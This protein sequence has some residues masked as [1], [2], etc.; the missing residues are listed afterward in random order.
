MRSTLFSRKGVW[1]VLLAVVFWT[2]AWQLASMAVDLPLLLPGPLLVVKAFWNLAGD[3]EFWAMVS[4][5]LLRVLGGF[6]LGTA[7]G[8]LIAVLTEF[9]PFCG[10]ILGP[11]IR[12]I[13]ATPVASF[14]LLCMLWLKSGFVPA[15]IA[16]LMVLPVIWGN[17]SEGF[18]QT[19]IQ[20]LEMAK[21][22]GFGRFRT[23]FLVYLP[24]ALPYFHT[25]CVT[26]LGM[27][28]KSGVAAEVLCQPK[29]AVGTQ[30]YYAKIYLETDNLFAWT[31]V[32]I[33]LSVVVEHLFLR[34]AKHLDMIRG[35]TLL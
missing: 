29:R 15:F 12:V 32:V 7:V 33:A 3:L 4:M 11:A 34:A 21:V 24:S 10:D 16:G 35:D 1:K 26:G 23:F 5:T 28:W 17:L 30:L 13:R 18:R 25:A 8:F 6:L 2:T 14:I 20:L 22:Y 19:D 9:V 31:A 27:A